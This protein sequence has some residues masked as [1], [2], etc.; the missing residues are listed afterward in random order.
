M[1]FRLFHCFTR[2]WRKRR[3]HKRQF[4]RKGEPI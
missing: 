3:A 1:M 2:K 4:V